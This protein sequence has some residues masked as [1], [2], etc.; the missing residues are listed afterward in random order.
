MVRNGTE[1]AEQGF[2]SNHLFDLLKE[3]NLNTIR[4]L[5]TVTKNPHN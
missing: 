3:N 2:F 4:I 1:D 5:E